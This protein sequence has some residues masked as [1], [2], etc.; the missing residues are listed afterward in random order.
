M[1]HPDRTFLKRM[2]ELLKGSIKRI[3]LICLSCSNTAGLLWWVTFSYGIM[4]WFSYVYASESYCTVTS[5]LMYLGFYGCG[6][7]GSQS[8]SSFHSHKILCSNQLPQRSYYPLYLHTC[9]VWGTLQRGQCI[10]VHSD[11]QV[12]VHVAVVKSDHSKDH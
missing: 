8:G 10:L 2:F 1:V 3:I 12:V 11:N 4:K 9:M 5:I 6:C 7:C